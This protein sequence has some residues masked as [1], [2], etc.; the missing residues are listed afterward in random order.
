MATHDMK[1]SRCPG[2]GEEMDKTTNVQGDVPPKPGDMGVC[3]ECGEVLVVDHDL[4]MVLATPADWENLDREAR[5]TLRV[6]SAGARHFA[7]QRR[8]R[9]STKA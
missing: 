3:A 9:P 8:A 2:C 6:A 5:F 1:P 4:E 7:R